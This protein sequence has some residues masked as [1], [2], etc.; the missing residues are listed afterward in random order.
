MKHFKNQITNIWDCTE[1]GPL[2]WFTKLRVSRN[3]TKGI[4]KISQETYLQRK[5]AEFGLENSRKV[6]TPMSPD[7]KLSKSMCPDSTTS[8]EDM[9]FI[10]SFPYRSLLGTLQYFRLTRADVLQAISECSKYANNPG[11]KHILAALR[12]LQYLHHHPDWGLL[13]TKSGRKYG[14]A[15]DIELYVDSDHAAD[16]D[17]RRSRTG[18]V[19]LVNN[20]VIDYGTAM[21]SKTATSTPVAEYVALASGLKQLLWISQ[22]IEE[23][24]IKVNYPCQV[25]EDNEGCIAIANNPMAQKRTRHMEIRYHFIRD[26][27]NDGKIKI[28]HCRTTR[29]LADMLTKA[30][31]GPALTQQRARIMSDIK[32]SPDQS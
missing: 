3:R 30:L 10:R 4:M 17:T 5:V 31:P 13:F 20:N 9:Q 24:E 26:Y 21:Q 2:K 8:E 32:V 1:G 19:I 7:C 6:T 28:S 15:W 27:V 23:C 29:M 22:I 14:S 25:H 12:I 18:Y 16:V 11:K